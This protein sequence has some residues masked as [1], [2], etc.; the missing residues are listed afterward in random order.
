[1][2]ICHAFDAYLYIHTCT[3]LCNTRTYIHVHTYAT[4]IQTYVR[5][6]TK[7]QEVLFKPVAKVVRLITVHCLTLDIRSQTQFWTTCKQ[8]GKEE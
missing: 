8:K 5:T 2:Y 4:H 1:M 7:Y 6:Y 3:Y